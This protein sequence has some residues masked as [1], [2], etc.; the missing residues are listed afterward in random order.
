MSERIAESAS[1]DRGGTSIMPV[2]ER[3]IL[4][5]SCTH[6]QYQAEKKIARKY[7]KNY[8][9]NQ[10]EGAAEKLFRRA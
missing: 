3:R 6:W 1:G 4:L 8:A 9:A 5:N 2:R 10:T 7:N